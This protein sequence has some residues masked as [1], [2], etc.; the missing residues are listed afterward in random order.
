MR[1]SA[2]HGNKIK[3]NIFSFV[4]ESAILLNQLIRRCA[5]IGELPNIEKL[6][7]DVCE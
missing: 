7:F 3:G 1:S 5:E 4:D 6:V 2:I